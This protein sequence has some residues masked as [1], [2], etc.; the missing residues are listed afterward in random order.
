M[1]TIGY[2]RRSFADLVETLAA[3]DVRILADVRTVPVCRWSEGFCKPY[4]LAHLPE[5]G[6]EYE[7]WPVLGGQGPEPPQRRDVQLFMVK[8]KKDH[9][10]VCLM[11]MCPDPRKCHRG[12]LL[13]P[14]FALEGVS[15]AHILRGPKPTAPGQL[16]LFPTHATSLD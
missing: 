9:R 12:L 14:L 11:C 3:H 16:E 13:Q 2:H 7:H 15:L 8:H 5:H 10:A 1:F 6:I 4:L